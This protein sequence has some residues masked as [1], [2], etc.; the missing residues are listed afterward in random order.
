MSS[1]L[2]YHRMLAASSLALSPALA[3]AIRS[4]APRMWSFSSAVSALPAFRP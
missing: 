2:A 4:T 1:A 3:A